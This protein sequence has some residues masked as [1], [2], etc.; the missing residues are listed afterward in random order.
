MDSASP[1]YQC[2]RVTR[3]FRDILEI[4]RGDRGDPYDLFWRQP[5]PLVPRRLRLPVTERIRANGEVWTELEENDVRAAT[6]VFAAEGVTSI[7]IAFLNSYANPAHEVA[8]ENA[9][10]EA[11]FRLRAG[12]RRRTKATSGPSK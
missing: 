8:A 12:E 7:A 5:E 4:A 10:R 11:G 2:S 1:Q 3:G 6:E 9:L